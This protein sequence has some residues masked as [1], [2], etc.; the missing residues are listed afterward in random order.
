[1]EQLELGLLTDSD[2]AG[3][4]KDMKSTSGVFLALY[5][6]H[7]FFPLCSASTKQTN[8]SHSS[9]EAELVA[10]NKGMRTEGLPA[11]DLWEQLLGRKVVLRLFQEN[12]A[13]ARIITTGKAPT[14]RHIKR[15]HQ[16]C[17]AWLHQV[18]AD[19]GL[20]LTDCD[21]GVMAADIFTKHFVNRDK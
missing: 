13:T 21:T 12:Q 15:T 19:L 4:R 16:V 10:C 20:L 9:V 1:M 14:L 17:I 3:D 2:F 6:T 11:L 18:V 8:V 5:G 7:T